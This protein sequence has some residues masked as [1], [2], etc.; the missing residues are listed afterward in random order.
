MMSVF[1][2]QAHAYMLSLFVSEDLTTSHIDI[3]V[4]IDRESRD[5]VMETLGI[6]PIIS[7][8]VSE[9]LFHLYYFIISD[10]K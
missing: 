8:N 9:K 3:D 10:E 1:F 5:V 4:D 2:S 6:F 7:F